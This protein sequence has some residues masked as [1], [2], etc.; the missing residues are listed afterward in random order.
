MI[1]K[2]QLRAKIRTERLALSREACAAGDHAIAKEI[3]S[4]DAYRMAD[5]L[6]LYSAVQN[7][8]DLT[9]V[10][11]AALADGKMV[12]YPRVAGGGIMHFHRICALD[13]LALSSFYIPAPSADAPRVTPTSRTLILIPALA[14]DR[15]GNR[16]GQGGG[17]YDRYLA[18]FP[19]AKI[20]IARDAWLVPTLPHEVHDVRVDMIITEKQNYKVK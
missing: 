16:L 8:V 2:R 3:L 15:D 9:E 19:G 20:G 17:Y 11:E 5:T 6:F 13:E 14:F 1:I 12:A 10:A 7:E 18:D 4:S